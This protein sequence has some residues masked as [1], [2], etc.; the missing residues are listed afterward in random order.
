MHN[1][2]EQVTMQC[3]QLSLAGF[4]ISG[5]ATY[6]QVPQLDVCFDMGECPLS[7]VPL[8]HVFLT[9][10][11]GD[12]ARCIPRHRALRGMLG[13]VGEATYFMPAAIADAFHDVARADARFEGVRDQDYIAP[14]VV[15]LVGDDR[16]VPLPYRKNTFVRAFPVDHRGV[17]SLG[18]TII[19]RRRKLLD[20]F[21]HLPGEEIAALRRAGTQVTS[22]TDAP[23]VTFI[24]DCVGSSLREQ[25]HIWKSAVLVI[26]ATFVD[27]NDRAMAAMKGHTHIDEV[28]EVIAALGPDALPE[29]IVL[30]HFSMRVTRD[31]VFAAIER[32]IPAFARSRIR[33]FMASKAF[34]PNE[35]AP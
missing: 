7:A 3:G 8:R 30:K 9:H 21:A 31:E 15:G 29:H 12:H 26:E 20:A 13:L 32:A 23:L 16:L 5:L 2:L 11:H 1:A 25:A 6:L 18:Y 10:A 28:G 27:P 14:T 34:S 24:G 4:S 33:P 35:G 17:P 19:E 22:D